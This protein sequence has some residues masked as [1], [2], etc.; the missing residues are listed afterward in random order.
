MNF[1]AIVSRFIEETG[2][3]D[4]GNDEPTNRLSGNLPDV[5]RKTTPTFMISVTFDRD[6]S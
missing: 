5:P 3:D 2:E 4:E 1:S 6:Q